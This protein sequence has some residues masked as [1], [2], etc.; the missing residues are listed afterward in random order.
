M[1][2][3]TYSFPPPL[4][5][6]DSSSSNANSFSAYLSPGPV[7]MKR[8]GPGQAQAQ[9]QKAVKLYRGVRQRHWG[10]WVAEIRLPKNRTRLWLG[11][12]DTAEEAALAYD[13]A[14][15]KLR[16]DGARLNFPNLRHVGS[17]VAAGDF[18]DYKPLHASVDAKL[19][20]ICRNLAA[21]QNSKPK[22]SAPPP[23]PPPPKAEVSESESGSRSGSGSGSGSS[24]PLSEL[25]FGD[26]D[27]ESY[28]LET[29]PSHEIDWDAIMASN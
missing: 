19:D 2:P 27:T 8:A 29:C 5:Y 4:P 7:A 12:F 22:K 10:K 1:G 26:G 24:S 25:T 20:V 13:T 3:A 17:H 14:A 21:Q 28:M 18:G 23:P 16:G 11:T 15:F 6:H 9:A